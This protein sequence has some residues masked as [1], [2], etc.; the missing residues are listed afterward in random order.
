MKSKFTLKR[1]RRRSLRDCEKISPSPINDDGVVAGLRKRSQSS[2]SHL[3]M[4]LNLFEQLIHKKVGPFDCGMR[5]IKT[6]IAWERV[7]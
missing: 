2:G 3:H 6:L 7:D 5:N 4:S 1:W